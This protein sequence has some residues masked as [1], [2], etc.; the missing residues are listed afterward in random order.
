[1][2][3]NRSGGTEF[4]YSKFHL[5][6][7]NFYFGLFYLGVLVYIALLLHDPAAITENMCDISLHLKDKNKTLSVLNY[8]RN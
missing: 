5:C 6:D 3:L 2:F 7:F 1:M 4:N 8:F